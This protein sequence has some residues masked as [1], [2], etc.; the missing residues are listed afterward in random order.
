[1]ELD[2]LFSHDVFRCYGDGGQEIDW[3]QERKATPQVLSRP[4][5]YRQRCRQAKALWRFSGWVV[6]TSTCLLPHL[7]RWQLARVRG[8]K[9]VYNGSVTRGEENRLEDSV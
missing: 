4:L 2:D 3:L 1:M 9:A 6:L 5:N 7:L 8:R